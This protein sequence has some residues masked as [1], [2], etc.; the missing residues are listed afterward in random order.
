MPRASWEF[1]SNMT[2]P[3]PTGDEQHAIAAFLDRETAQIDALIARQERLLAVLQEKRQALIAHAVT[4]G[5]NPQAAMKESGVEWLGEVPAHWEVVPLRRLLATIEQGQTLN[6]ENRPVEAGEWGVLKSGCV[7]G[8]KF[9][10]EENKALAEGATFDPADEVKVGDILMSRAS[11]SLELVGS[12]ALVEDTR[13][14]LL[15]SDKTFRLI[16]TDVI[17]PRFLVAQLT[18][19]HVRNQIELLA[20][21]AEGLPNNI[22]KPSINSLIVTLP[23]MKEQQALVDS[24]ACSLAEIERVLVR[25]GA[26]IA[27]LQE[28]SAALISAAVTGKID[29]RC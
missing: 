27:L 7:N 5:L 1:I 17:I 19:R 13:P 4:K 6:S 21:G 14:G 11:G 12:V 20:N 16:A 8:G 26:M 18:S 15:L 29:V 23:P 22:T 3:V 10:S 2:V 25:S 28:R 24:L 9:R